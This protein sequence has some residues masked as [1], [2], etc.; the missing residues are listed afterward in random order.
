MIKVLYCRKKNYD[1]IIL[2]HVTVT[3]KYSVTKQWRVNS[4]ENGHSPTVPDR[5]NLTGNAK[6]STLSILLSVPLVF[7]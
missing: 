7:P 4:M 2:T 5:S 1:T 6:Q 3:S